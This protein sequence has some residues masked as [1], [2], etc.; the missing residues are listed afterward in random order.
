M[1]ACLSSVIVEVCSLMTVVNPT[2]RRGENN[3]N[4]NQLHD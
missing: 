3:N 1:S 4:R 2:M